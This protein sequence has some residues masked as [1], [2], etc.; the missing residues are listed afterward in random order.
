M[1]L[2]RHVNARGQFLVLDHIRPNGMLSLFSFLDR[3][4]VL[5][6]SISDVTTSGVRCVPARDR[7]LGEQIPIV[8]GCGGSG[9]DGPRR[10]DCDGWSMPPPQAIDFTVSHA[11]R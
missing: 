7:L 9:T 1:A 6:G 8:V 3:P 4:F 10:S 11:G 5:Q 2:R